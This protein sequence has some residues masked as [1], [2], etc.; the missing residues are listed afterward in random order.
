MAFR[1]YFYNLL[2]FLIY[3]YYCRASGF[4]GLSLKGKLRKAI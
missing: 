1:F 3:S 4:S 2:L